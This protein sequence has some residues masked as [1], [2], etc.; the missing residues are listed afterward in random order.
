M[1]TFQGD[2]DPSN[3]AV[4]DCEWKFC[5][6]AP[7]ATNGSLLTDLYYNGTKYR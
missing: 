4:L 1:I 7:A 6:D 5:I 3:V 2:W